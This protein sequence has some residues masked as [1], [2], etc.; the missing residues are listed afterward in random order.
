VVM[1]V[2]EAVDEDAVAGGGGGSSY[3][4]NSDSD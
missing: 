4:N 1:T 3:D 2:N